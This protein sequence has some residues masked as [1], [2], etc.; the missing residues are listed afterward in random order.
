[1]KWKIISLCVA[2]YFKYL[3]MDDLAFAQGF[4]STQQSGNLPSKQ[5]ITNGD[6]GGRRGEITEE[7]ISS[8]ASPHFI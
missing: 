7:K 3:R 1:M 6:S 2:Y 8:V 5:L 4:L